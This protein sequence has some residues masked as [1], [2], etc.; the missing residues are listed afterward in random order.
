[1][2]MRFLMATVLA[3]TSLGMA[4]AADGCLPEISRIGRKALC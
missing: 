3:W 1:M 4:V 2:I